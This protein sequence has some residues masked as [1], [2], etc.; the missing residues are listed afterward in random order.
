MALNEFIAT[1]AKRD[2]ARQNRFATEIF[3]P[4]ALGV[5][6]TLSGASGVQ[7][8]LPPNRQVNMLCESVTFPGQNIRTASDDL[9][10]GPSREI[11]QGVTYGDITLSFICTPGLP[12]K[13]FFEIWQSMMFNSVTWQAK[14]YNEYIGEI[15]LYQ[16]DREDVP[17]YGIRIYEAYPKII[18][19]QDYSYSS[20]DSYQTLSVEFA[21]HHWTPLSDNDLKN[22][23]LAVGA[24]RTAALQPP[25]S[26]S[27]RPPAVRTLD[28][29]RPPQ[30]G[31]ESPP[32]V[33]QLPPQ[34]R[35]PMAVSD[36]PAEAVTGRP[37]EF[38]SYTG[39]APATFAAD[40][41]DMS[42]VRRPPAPNREGGPESGGDHHPPYPR[43]DAHKK[44]PAANP[45]S[46]P[47]TG[48]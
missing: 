22:S 23:A 18:T 5:T 26:G 32:Q 42:G 40:A 6:D 13:R 16:L 1:I 15:K 36:N 46:E 45:H 21:L 11:G 47:P 38:A 19:G 10:S 30:A 2:V 27:E 34:L 28:Q 17:R 7:V 44:H 37:P 4:G 43:G 12:E 24:E 39:L 31:A 8:M 35:K 20:S 29:L 3:P 14:F 9:R 33:E 41:G 25:T 48:R